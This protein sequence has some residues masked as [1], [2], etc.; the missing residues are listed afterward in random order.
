MSFKN[1][2]TFDQLNESNLENELHKL[3]R[4]LNSSRLSTYREG[5]NSEE[6]K[7]R[8]KERA[9]K[10]ARFN[11]VLALLNAD[12]KN[13]KYI[14]KKDASIPKSADTKELH[15]IVRRLNTAKF[16]FEFTY[17]V[18]Y[19]DAGDGERTALTGKWWS[20]IDIKDSL[21]GALGQVKYVKNPGENWKFYNIKLLRQFRG[22][23]VEREI[24]GFLEE[25]KYGVK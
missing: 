6:E 16:Q 24:E 17:G 19:P 8:Q 7:A 18:P 1:L 4:D 22:K 11:E 20:G 14:E 15:N 13:D 5:D 21:Y 10:L 9:V 12:S 2:K 23:P 3:Q 25:I